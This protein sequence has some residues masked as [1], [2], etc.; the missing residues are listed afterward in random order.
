[1]IALLLLIPFVCYLILRTAL[2]ARHSYRELASKVVPLSDKG[3]DALSAVQI[4]GMPATWLGVSDLIRIRRNTSLFSRLAGRFRRI[5]PA[6]TDEASTEAM[7]LTYRTF[8][9]NHRALKRS[10]MAVAAHFCVGKIASGRCSSQ[11]SL[12][13]CLYANEVIL[14]EEMSEVMD[15]PSVAVLESQFSAWQLKIT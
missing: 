5:I 4:P 9:R 14:V 12:V 10:L 2:R 7:K 1:M 15:E 11:M 3:R 13:E 6:C 8:S